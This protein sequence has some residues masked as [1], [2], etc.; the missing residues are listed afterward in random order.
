MNTRLGLFGGSFNPIHM[1]HLRM[2]VEA[3]QAASLDRVEFLPAPR[4]PHK[5]TTGML[6]FALRWRLVQLAVCG[7]EGFFPSTAEAALSGPSYTLRTLRMYRRLQPE[8]DLHFI[9]GAEDLLKL[10]TWHKGAELVE[11]ASLVALPRSGAG[12][13][14]VEHFVAEFWPGAAR[15]EQ[16]LWSFPS[17]TTLRFVPAPSL[18]VSATR[19]R[20]AVLAGESIAYLVPREVEK[21]L[22][23]LSEEDLA[24]WRR[25]ESP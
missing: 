14:E 12:R 9:L 24:P 2:A 16:D 13:G 25:E 7:R 3:A 23:T 17:G 18:D 8:T 5:E 15:M 20:R 4:P 19:I 22:E 1:G 6:S 21:A 11:H 10:P